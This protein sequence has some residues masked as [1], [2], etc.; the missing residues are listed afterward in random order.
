MERAVV[1]ALLKASLVGTRISPLTFASPPGRRIQWRSRSACQTVIHFQRRETMNYSTRATVAGN[2]KPA[3]LTLRVVLAFGLAAAFLG[4]C[5]TTASPRPSFPP[6]LGHLA[7]HS[8]FTEERLVKPSI[9]KIRS[10]SINSARKGGLQLNAL[11][12]SP[13]LPSRP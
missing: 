10:I 3:V 7:G 4:R 13:F 6:H 2:A 8:L 12:F 9:L 1:I 11:P 5:A